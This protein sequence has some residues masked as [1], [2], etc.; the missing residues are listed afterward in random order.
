MRPIGMK[1]N[2]SARAHRVPLRTTLIVTAALSASGLLLAACSASPSA[3][4]AS[5]SGSGGAAGRHETASGVP[6]AGSPSFSGQRTPLTTAALVSPQSI[7]YTASLTITAKNVAAAATAAAAMV[8][9]VGGYVSSE[10]ESITPGHGG[11]AQANLELK[12]PVAEY[13]ATLSRLAVLGRRTSLSQQAQDVTQQV[14][15]VSSRV[16]SAQAAIRQLR[17]LLS[18]AGSISA[19]L[20]VQDQI[21]SQESELEA[22]LAQQRALAHQTSYGT[23]SLLLVSH[24]VR[25]VKHAKKTSH[26]FAAGLGAGWRGLKL[27]ITGLLTALGAALPFAL[28]VALLT[29]I[30]YGGRRR[31]TRRRMPR[32]AAPPPAAS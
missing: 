20:S 24:H 4:S 28:P 7:I 21:N 30:G 12:I 13:A 29:G 15:D 8:N 11:S 23:V 16:I 9:A 1:T 14:A 19:L 2:A 10:Q 27:V 22:L 26:G 32:A 5:A 18:R 3:S 31:L 17:T 6:E 25:A